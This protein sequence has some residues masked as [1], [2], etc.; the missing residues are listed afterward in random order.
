[1]KFFWSKPYLAYAKDKDITKI[2]FDILRLKNRN[3]NLRLVHSC[4]IVAEERP[5]LTLTN[6]FTKLYQGLGL[7]PQAVSTSF[8]C[9][10]GVA[11]GLQ[12]SFFV[13]FYL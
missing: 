8:G 11:I 5:R 12:V 10:V 7:T 6:N 4:V 3:T 9:R 2:N 1:V 13:N